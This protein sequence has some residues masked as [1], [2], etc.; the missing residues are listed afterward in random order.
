MLWG[1]RAVSA[2]PEAVS[3]RRTL[4]RAFLAGK[5]F[6]GEGCGFM[7]QAL[8]FTAVF[9]MFPLL[10]LAIAGL[11]YVYG[12]QA[13][14]ARVLDTIGRIA[15]ALLDVTRE[16]LASVVAF[17]SVSSI[18]SLLGLWWSSKNFF[19]GLRYALNRSL[20]L[21]STR[22]FLVEILWSLIAVP[23]A[24]LVLAIAGIAPVALSLLLKWYGATPQHELS[25]VLGNIG[26]SLLVFGVTLVLYSQLP[27]QR[28]SWRFGLPGAVVFAVAWV[29]IQSL[30][31]IYTSYVNFFHIFGALSAILAL[32]FWFYLVGVT[33]L[34][35]AQLCAVWSDENELERVPRCICSSSSSP[36]S[37]S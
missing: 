10:L 17:R 33:F 2:L 1:C 9:A 24:C 19:L 25:V 7:A 22:P 27:A 23:A 32:L 8:A 37:S 14:Q 30:F 36:L 3:V 11:G 34:Y 15:P 13:G 5:R 29:V 20:G 21:T 4:H 6:S 28:L 18:L 35:G 16:N 26:S 31:G 12:S